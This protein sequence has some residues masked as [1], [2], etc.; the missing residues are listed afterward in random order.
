MAEKKGF[1]PPIP[2]TGISDFESDAFDHSATSPGCALNDILAERLG[3]EPR[4]TYA[5]TV[6]KTVTLNRSAISP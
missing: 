4:V 6:F 2:E 3:F 5:T 1:E